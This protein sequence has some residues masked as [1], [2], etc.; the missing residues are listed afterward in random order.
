MTF[1]EA[2]ERLIGHEG[3]YV[4]HPNDPG[5]ET[6]WGITRSVARSE[7]YT[8]SMRDMPRS[9]AKEI[10]R[11]AYWH[12]AKA[13]QYDPA[14]GFQV[15]DAA[16]NHGIGQAIRKVKHNEGLVLQAANV[17]FSVAFL[18]GGQIKGRGLRLFMIY[19]E[20][21]FIEC[22]TDTPYLQIGEHKY[23]KPVLDRAIKY[24]VNLYDALKVG[25]VSMDSTMRSNLG[26][27]MPID[28][29]VIRKDTAD[30]ELVHRINDDDAYFK[31]LRQIWSA[32][33]RAAHQNI[34]PPPYRGID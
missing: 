4:N 18:L 16:V 34:P 28:V 23:G 6:N 5:G 9:T 11:R 33:L 19:P 27:G 31:D 22:T 29:V 13:D 20:G 26:V 3:G 14:I 1:D 24:D 15:F 7:G 21:N 8:G 30:A 12:R 32:A 25:L 10:D 2:F 17:D